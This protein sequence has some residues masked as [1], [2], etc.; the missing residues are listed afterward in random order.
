MNDRKKPKIL[1]VDDKEYNRKLMS[2]L[3]KNYGYSYETATNGFEALVKTKE[4]SP[5]LIF[6]DVLM[7]EMDGYEACMKLKEDP[8]TKNIPVVMVTALTDKESRVKGLKYGANDFISKPIDSTEVMVRAQN[9]IKVK[10]YEDFLKKHNELL[11]KKVQKRTK[12]IE[13]ALRKIDESKK[14][15]RE[16]YIETVLTLTVI[17]EYK[18][19]ETAFHIQRIGHYCKLIAKYLSWSKEEQEIILF[20]SPLHDIGKVR[21]PAEVLLRQ[22]KLTP[23]EFSIMKTHTTVASRILLKSKSKNLQ[24]AEKIARTHHERFDGTGYPEGLKGEEIPIEG[25]IAILADQYDSLRGKRPY[26]PPYDH[27]KTF[28]IITVGDG[29]TMPQHFDPKILDIF[30]ERHKLFKEIY[31]KHQGEVFP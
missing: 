18:D 27:E 29:R 10:E 8:A 20:A 2:T 9:L 26:K 28:E 25:R 24:M 21:I 13:L 6:L 14:E 11:E 4:Y 15:L 16:N 3:L 22:S 19:E 7:P 17:A 31:D 5:D 1:I 23:E 12:Q 30:K